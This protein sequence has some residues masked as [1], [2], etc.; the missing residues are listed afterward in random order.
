[1]QWLPHS[2]KFVN[3]ANTCL[4]NSPYSRY[5]ITYNAVLTVR[6]SKAHSHHFLTDM[7]IPTPLG[8]TQLRCNNCANNIH[9][10]TYSTAYSHA[11]IYTG[12]I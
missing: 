5:V 1:M 4:A 2:G 9:S 11:F 6:T 3:K 7:L 10:L 12:F 8:S